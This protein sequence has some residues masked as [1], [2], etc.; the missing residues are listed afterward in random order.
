[1]YAKLLLRPTLDDLC[2]APYLPTSPLDKGT[3]GRKPGVVKPTGPRLSPRRI[4]ID[5]TKDARTARAAAGWDSVVPS[6]PR[7]LYALRARSRS[8]ASVTDP[9]SK[10]PTGGQELTATSCPHCGA[11]HDPGASPCHESMVGRTLRDGIRIR[12]QLGE[13]SLG[14]HYRAEY[15]TGL[16]VVVLI[17]NSTSADSAETRPPAAR[18]PPRDPGPASEC[19]RDP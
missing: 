8:V 17:L 7:G 19:R 3:P 6:T 18:L 16:E 14:P 13:T 9:A 12:E 10:A 4:R 11:Q 5:A 1:M 15:P 2:T